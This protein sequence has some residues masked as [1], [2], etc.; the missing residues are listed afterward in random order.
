VV[1]ALSAAAWSCGG[2][3]EPNEGSCQEGH[4]VGEH[5]CKNGEWVGYTGPCLH[6]ACEPNGVCVEDTSGPH[7]QCD[8][9]YVADNGQCVQQTPGSC[10]DVDCGQGTCV[11]NGGAEDGGNGG[12]GSTGVH[13]R[14]V[15]YD[16]NGDSVD[17]I[18]SSPS[19]APDQSPMNQPA[20]AVVDPTS[21]Q[22]DC[23]SVI[24]IGN[25]VL[26]VSVPFE[27]ATGDIGRCAT[28]Y[29]Q[30]VYYLDAQCRGTAYMTA[31]AF[32]IARVGQEVVWPQGEIVEPSSFYRMNDG[33]CEERTSTTKLVPLQ[34]VPTWIRDALPNPPYT[35][36][37]EY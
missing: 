20:G 15:L 18:V 21:V 7:C 9:G 2:T 28:D 14:W 29:T 30:M 11:V 37:P 31:S 4:V 16:G 22:R 10:D 36:R 1:A 13:P 8:D 32:F 12:G 23:A 6:L 35:V 24:A 5:V 17:A 26:P 27:L 33:T 25:D 19:R 3:D 34:P